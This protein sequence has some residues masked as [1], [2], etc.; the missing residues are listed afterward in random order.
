MPGCRRI[1]R[2]AVVA[3]GAVVTR[4]VPDESVAYGNPA[5]VKKTLKELKCVLGIHEE[6]YGWE[7]E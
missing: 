5:K 3:A 6:V 4:D 1:G 7:K 2:G